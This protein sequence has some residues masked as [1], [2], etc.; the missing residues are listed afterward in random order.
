LDWTEVEGEVLS[1]VKSVFVGPGFDPRSLYFP[2]VFKSRPIKVFEIRETP[3]T[4][5]ITITLFHN[6]TILGSWTV[7]M[8]SGLKGVLESHR[9][10]L[11]HTGIDLS[12]LSHPSIM[13]LTKLLIEHYKPVRFFATYAEP[14][15]YNRGQHEEFLL[16]EELLGRRSVPG[17]AKRLKGNPIK[18]VSVLGFDGDR[19][20]KLAEESS[21]ITS[22]VPVVGFPSYKPG[23]QTRTLESSLR[24]IETLNI[25]TDIHKCSANSIYGL[26]ELLRKLKPKDGETYAIAPLGTRPHTMASAIYAT[27]NSDTHIIYDHPVEVLKRTTGIHKCICYNITPFVIA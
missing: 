25:E 22:I 2:D 18:L 7:D 20:M 17:F 16:T 9:K 14:Q 11:T 15:E 19:L 23:W 21:N 10:D 6:S 4:N 26:I 3:K 1:S 8:V 5:E 13:Y 24:A 27:Q 12:S